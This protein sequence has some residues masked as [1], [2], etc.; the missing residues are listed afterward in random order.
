MHEQ[1]F[2]VLSY[3][4]LQ[5]IM[6]YTKSNLNQSVGLLFSRKLLMA[7]C[8]QI[9]YI[10]SSSRTATLLTIH[11]FYIREK[12]QISGE[13]PDLTMRKIATLVVEHFPP[14]PLLK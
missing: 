7:R 8:E 2:N 11:P 13:T 5:Q 3:P 14:L 6:L 4:A 9:I 10:K 12:P 1:S